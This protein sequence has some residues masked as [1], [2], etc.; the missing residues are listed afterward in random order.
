MEEF[1]QMPDVEHK[2]L[3][4]NETRRLTGARCEARERLAQPRKDSEVMEEF[5]KMPDVEHKSLS[6]RLTGG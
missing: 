1:A 5:A 6:G 3:Q 2:R 4:G